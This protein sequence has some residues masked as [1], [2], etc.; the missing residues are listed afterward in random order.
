MN[1]DIKNT[2]KVTYKFKLVLAKTINYKL[3]VFSK[4]T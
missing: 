2:N 1:K 3:E 4:D